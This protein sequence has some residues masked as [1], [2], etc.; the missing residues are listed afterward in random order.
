MLAKTLCYALSGIDATA[1]TVEAYVSGGMLFQFSMVGL[2]DT[3]VRESRD[4]VIA[5]IKNSGFAM[6]YGHTT[7]NLS[8]ADIKKEGAVFD[9][10]I[11]VSI[12]HATK[13]LKTDALHKTL[14]LGELALDGK[15]NPVQGVLPM[16]ISALRD[17]I[18]KVILPEKNAKEVEVLEGIEIYPCRCLFDA[19]AH[20]S[21]KS[22][23]LPQKQKSYEECLSTQ[24]V[25]LDLSQVRGQQAAKRALEIA[26]AGQHSI[27][28]VGVPGSG[29]TMLARC[30]QGI[31]PTMTKAEAFETTRIYSAAGLLPPG[32]GLMTVRPFRTP[33]HTAS[34]AALI[35]G[36]ANAKPGEV[37]LAHNGVLYLDEM[38]E[39]PRK[40]LD[41]LRQPLEDG[42]AS[43]SRV[44]AHVNYL[45][46]CMMVA[47]MNPCPCGYYGSTN[48]E[49]R[50]GSHEIRKYL[51]RISGPLLD[52]IDIQIEVDA[53]PI[54]EVMTKE[55]AESSRDVR[56]RVEKARQIQLARFKGSAVHCNSQMSSTQIENMI[57]TSQE[58]SKFLQMAMKK[59]ALSMRAYSRILKVAQTICDLKEQEI[60][61]LPAISEA[62][63][64]RLIDNK[65]WKA[66]K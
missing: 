31:L 64:F 49:C 3:A 63:Q 19:V 16:V 34:S 18:K 47:S 26:A 41:A 17:G 40:V 11:A 42:V 20:L 39:Y 38:P 48:R 54:E 14:L 24:E 44:K 10:A 59:Y 9:L 45:S 23:L 37:S 15:L 27:L 57:K 35:G 66:G 7:I 50:C 25:P 22:P 30:L 13:Q 58:A 28:F 33:H 61:D 52:R 4:R 56:V 65:Y 6:P 51:D 12:I 46:K 53:V 43:I 36:G 1:V 55:K 32:S 21:G 29:K 62:V 2:P 60:I 5:A 8:P